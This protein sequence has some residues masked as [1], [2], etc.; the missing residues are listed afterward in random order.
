MET[1]CVS[2]VCTAN[3]TISIIKFMN[4][5]RVKNEEEKKNASIQNSSIAQDVSLFHNF[6]IFE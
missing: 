5:E 3:T 2:V 4:M 1:M 6:A